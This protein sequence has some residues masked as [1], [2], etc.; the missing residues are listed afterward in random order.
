MMGVRCLLLLS[1]L[2]AG[3]ALAS[4]C[5]R[6]DFPPI[7]D[8]GS[9]GATPSEP[10]GTGGNRGGTGSGSGTNAVGGIVAAGSGGSIGGTSVVSSAVGGTITGGSGGS[11]GGVCDEIPCLAPMVR[12]CMPSGS[13]TSQSA[14]AG[15]VPTTTYCYANGVKEQTVVRASGTTSIVATLTVKRDAQICYSID[16]SMTDPSAISYAFRDGSGTQV[17][18]GTGTSSASLPV[19]TCNGGSPTPISIACGALV[20]ATASCTPGS[21]TF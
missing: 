2:V 11:G 18:T 16:V 12:G 1:A 17:A 15:L 14:T 5:G 7:P 13:C 10:S 3:L 4:A 21:C 19:V 20:S 6:S 8:A 9:T